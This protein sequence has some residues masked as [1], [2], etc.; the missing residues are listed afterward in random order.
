MRLVDRLRHCSKQYL[1]HILY[2][3]FIFS[4][5][6]CV[7]CIYFSHHCWC[8]HTLHTYLLALLT[9]CS[10]YRH[11]ILCNKATEYIWLKQIIPFWKHKVLFHSGDHWMN[12]FASA[13]YSIRCFF[14]LSTNLQLRTTKH[15]DSNNFL[16]WNLIASLCRFLSL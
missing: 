3:V 5:Y 7:Y 4:D 10:S 1:I 2:I 6:F 11:Y 8:E 14:L 12:N 16:G 13:Y 9:S 15:K